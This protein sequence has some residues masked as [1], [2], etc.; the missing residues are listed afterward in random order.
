MNTLAL[1]MIAVGLS[2]DAFAVSV[3]NGMIIKPLQLKHAL[4]TAFFFGGFQALMP[5]IGWAAG[6][7]FSEYISGIDHWVAFI[8]L[9]IIGAKMIY[10]SV[11]ASSQGCETAATREDPTNNRTLTMLAIATSIDAL[12]VGVSFS[13]LN[14][15]IFSAAMII[16]CITFCFSFVG[17]L[18]GEKCGQLFQKRAEVFG[19]VMLILI[20]LKILAE[21]TGVLAAWLG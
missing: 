9:G 17:V 12:A 20:G 19:G 11:K 5:V 3:T 21:H 18:F 13:F 10:E 14:V 4:K 15:A 6:I 2:M 1:I 7:N 16:G 8:V